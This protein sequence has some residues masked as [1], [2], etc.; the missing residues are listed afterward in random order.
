M[1]LG[2]VLFLLGLVTGF[3][4]PLMEN[5][6]MGL[7][8]HLEGVINGI[9][10]VSLGLLWP[11]LRLGRI[12]KHITLGFAVYGSF[13]NWLS[14][15]LA[16]FWGAGEPMMPLA[17]SGYTGTSMQEGLIVF[18]LISLSIAVLIVS[19]IVLWGL[20]GPGPAET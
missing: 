4:L 15:L 18:G 12:A 6:R 1:R 19:V 10:L 16:G 20:R 17:A 7:S 14:T 9:F 5:P 11:H 3:T 8:S 13:A 2:I